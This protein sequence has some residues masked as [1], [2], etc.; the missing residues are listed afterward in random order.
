ML[1]SRTL[2]VCYNK[3][4]G[5]STGFTTRLTLPKKWIDALGFTPNERNAEVIYDGKKI[6]IK[7]LD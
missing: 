1:E 6:I 5:T 4:G 2:R 3:S 7:K